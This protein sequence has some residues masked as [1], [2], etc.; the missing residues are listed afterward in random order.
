[1][2]NVSLPAVLYSQT[3]SLSNVD[4]LWSSS[5]CCSLGS[6]SG[7]GPGLTPGPAGGVTPAAG[8]EG[9]D[10]DPGPGPSLLGVPVQSLPGDP[11]LL[12]PG[13]PGPH[14]DPNPHPDP[15]PDPDPGPGLSLGL[16]LETGAGLDQWVTL[17]LDLQL[18]VV[19]PLAVLLEMSDDLK[20]YSEEVSQITMEAAAAHLS[21]SRQGDSD[22][23]MLLSG[24]SFPAG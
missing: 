11:D 16:D 3:A 24:N 20:A 9:G 19:R 5:D 2:S 7:P 23:K 21:W 12:H 6:G 13:S 22:Y 18:E 1:M 10:P 8:A 14:P 4:S 15:D 17:D